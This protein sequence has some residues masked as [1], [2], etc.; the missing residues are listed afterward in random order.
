MSLVY[1]IL[2][3]GGVFMA[4]LKGTELVEKRNVLNELKAQN[5]TLQE[6]RFFS[7]YLSK[8][9][10]RDISTRKIKFPLSD[11]QKIMDLG[12]MN[13]QHVKQATDGLLTKLVHI[14]NER[15]GYSAFQL[16]KKCT[17]DQD[18]NGVWYVEIDAHDEA[19]PLM[20]EFKKY[21]FT[22]ELWN[23]LT[24]ASKNQV[25]MYEILKQ[26]EFIEKRKISLEELKT[27]LGIEPNEYPVWS[28]FKKRVLD[29]CQKALTEHTDITFTYEP[30]RT[31]HKFT[32]VTFF[33][34]R[35]KN[36]VDHLKLDDYIQRKKPIKIAVKSKPSE[37]WIPLDKNTDDEIVEE[38]YGDENLAFLA[39]ACDYEFSPQET[40]V[41]FDY[42]LER[43]LVGRDNSIKR[44]NLLYRT[45]NRLNALPNIP[46]RDSSEKNAHNRR[47]GF[48]KWSIENC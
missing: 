1:D 8:I 18:E 6:I 24:L 45:Y 34:K 47:F 44:Y 38:I 27:F 12:R 21:Y 22:Y 3:F 46:K 7:I 10:A 23:V 42:L 5:M 26:Y 39:G 15:G 25:R 36:Y 41:L 28:D 33:I 19:L 9:N 31:G 20:F 16:F 2:F 14:K 11:F 48:M 32:A 35:N 43:G 30:V 29:S 4:K 13:I 40:R 17:V 37:K